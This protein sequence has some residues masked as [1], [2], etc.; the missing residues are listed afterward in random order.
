MPPSR[1][2]VEEV[3]RWFREEFSK[4]WPPSL[5]SLTLRRSPCIRE[6]CYACETGEEH[7]SY[8]L[9]A[10]QNGRRVSVYIPTRLVPQ[11]RKAVENGRAVQDL[12]YEFGQ[13][14]A[15]ALKREDKKKR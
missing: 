13:R 11:I 2:T 10:K 3:E 6:H 8:V 9:L 5:G 7:S 14:Y 15:R 4:F 1:D 12:M